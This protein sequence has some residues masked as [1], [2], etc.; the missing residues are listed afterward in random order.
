M[1][2][3]YLENDYEIVLMLDLGH[4]EHLTKSR[5]CHPFLKPQCWVQ[6]EKTKGSAV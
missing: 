3:R 4:I 5:K 6:A 2:T 1:Q